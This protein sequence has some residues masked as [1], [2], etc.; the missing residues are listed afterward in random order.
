MVSCF[1]LNSALSVT[2]MYLLLL[3]AVDAAEQVTTCD[4]NS[5]QVHHMNCGQGVIKVEKALYGRSAAKVCAEGTSQ[6]MLSN[7][8]C[9]RPDTL[10]K[11]KMSCDGKQSCEL[12]LEDFRKPD[13]CAG[14]SKYLQTEFVCMPAVIVVA[15]EMSL[16]H[17]YCGFDHVIQVYGADYGRR[18]ENV[19]AYKRQPQRTK[20]KE[21]LHPTDI[22]AKRCNGKSSCSISASNRVFGD[23][24][25]GTYKYLEVAYTCTYPVQSHIS[26]S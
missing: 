9:A 2:V 19:C 6:K 5:R 4:L 13:P 7:T 17:L 11:V 15:C 10:D 21:C 12:F 23:P 8:Q 25:P 14:T 24:C 20:N 16:A 3:T 22:V 18:D 26:L 1:G